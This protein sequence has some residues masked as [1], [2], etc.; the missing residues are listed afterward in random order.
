MF[1][2]SDEKVVD[3][4]RPEVSVS[5]IDIRIVGG[6]QWLDEMSSHELV[7][8]QAPL[9]EISDERRSA[10]EAFPS[11]SRDPAVVVRIP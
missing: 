11:V 6:Y 8:E 5:N 1:F 9:D 4:H 2:C 10:Y 3:G 7:T